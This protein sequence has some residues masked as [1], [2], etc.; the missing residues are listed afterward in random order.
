M[1][2]GL[3]KRASDPEDGRRKIVVLTAKGGEQYRRLKARLVQAR[4]AFAA[5]F[6]EIGGDLPAL[7]LRAMDA[8]NERPLT[9]R[10]AAAKRVGA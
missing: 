2:L 7:I 4:A 8:L 10:V 3:V 5:L 6:E 9:Q 1:D